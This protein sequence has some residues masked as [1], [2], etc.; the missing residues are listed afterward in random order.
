MTT[1]QDIFKFALLVLGGF[2]CTTLDAQNYPKNRVVNCEGIFIVDSAFTFIEEVYYPDGGR[3]VFY[4]DSIGVT[5]NFNCLSCGNA[6]YFD[7]DDSTLSMDTL[8]RNGQKIFKVISGSIG[9]ELAIIFAASNP[10][11]CITH[12]VRLDSEPYIL[13]LNKMIEGKR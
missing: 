12:D 6:N 5:L 9:E 4:S 10:Q 11:I 3:A 2:V 8:V 1:F 13:K 7:A